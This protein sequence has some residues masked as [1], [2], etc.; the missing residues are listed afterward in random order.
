MKFKTS[1]IALGLAVALAACSKKEETVAPEAAAPIEQAAPQA[2]A[3]VT[4]QDG[5]VTIYSLA[6]YTKIGE[7]DVG[8][9]GR[10]I[11]RAHV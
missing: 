6:D 10:E 7:I 2:V 3:Y 5:P 4:H 1:A 9:G 8:E 11:G